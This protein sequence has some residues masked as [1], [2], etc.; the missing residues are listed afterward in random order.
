MIKWFGTALFFTCTVCCFAAESKPY[1]P[2]TDRMSRLGLF[3]GGAGRSTFAIPKEKPPLPEQLWIE[4]R[5]VNG[6]NYNVGALRQWD[7]HEFVK[8]PLFK[9]RPLPD[10][11]L[12]S[13]KVLKLQGERLF[14]VSEQARIVILMNHPK[15]SILTKGD[16]IG[17]YA[18]RVGRDGDYPLYDHGV[19]VP[20]KEKGR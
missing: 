6:T 11:D 1:R 13:G 5:N 19:L 20:D 8:G 18:M 3:V 10:W 12:V 15:A 14:V 2:S 4:L 17:V 16:E 9:S 7:R